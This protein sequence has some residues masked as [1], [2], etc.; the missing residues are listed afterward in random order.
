MGVI[1][2]LDLKGALM[3]NTLQG[4]RL[5]DELSSVHNHSMLKHCPPLQP[6]EGSVRID[7]DG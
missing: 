2:I 4:Y 5:S 7:R 3:E 1:Q 6:L